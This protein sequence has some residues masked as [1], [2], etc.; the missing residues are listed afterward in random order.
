LGDQGIFCRTEIFRE[1]GGF[2]NFR[3]FEDVDFSRR[4]SRE[5]KVVTLRPPVLSSAR[6]FAGGAV[7]R[8]LRDLFLTAR[9]LLRPESFKV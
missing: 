6:R 4:L 2:A 5:G 9:Y 7:K 1:L 8:T 3:A